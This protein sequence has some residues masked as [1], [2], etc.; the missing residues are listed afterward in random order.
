MAFTFDKS[1]EQESWSYFPCVGFLNKLFYSCFYITMTKLELLE[2]NFN[3]WG[4][5]IDVLM[6]AK[7]SQ[8]EHKAK[9]IVNDLPMFIH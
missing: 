9:I 7:H 1:T 6:A 8:T 3:F 2:R 5:F 4:D